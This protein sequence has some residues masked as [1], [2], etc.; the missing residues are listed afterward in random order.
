MNIF[1]CFLNSERAI[2]FRLICR[3][4]ALM[5][6]WLLSI[7]TGFCACS[8]DD[9]TSGEVKVQTI[10]D[11]LAAVRDYVPLYAVIAHR[12]STYWAPEETESAWRWAREM[13]ADYLESD[14]QCSKDGIIIANHD[15]SLKRT[16]NIEEV[17][18]AGIPETRI[19]FYESLG[20]SHDDATEQYQRDQ[21]S[22]QPYYM[23][24]YYYA[25]LL[26]LDAGKW[27]N[28]ALPTQAR[29]PFVAS[30]NGSFI[31]GHLRYSTGQY[32]STLQ[33]QIAYASGKMLR[34]G[35]DGERVLPYHI[36]PEYQGMTLR[37]IWQVITSKK[38]YDD[39]YM[40]FLDY[41]FTDAYTADPQDTG[42]RPGIYIEFKEPALNPDNMEQRVY[43]ILDH[44]GWN[45]ITQPAK[46]TAFYVG[47]KVNVGRTS[48]KVIL[49]TF[50]KEA[51]S[52]AN[53]IFQERVP[54]CYLLWL[55]IPP[56]PD[57]FDLTTPKGFAQAIKWAQDNGAH[58]M[59]PSIAGLPNNYS[60]LNAPWQAR[61]TR[62]SGMLNHPYSFD[63]QQQMANYV[64]TTAEDIPADG[65]F[66]NRS[67]LTLQYLIDKGFRGRSG[68]P[69]P[70][71][72]DRTYDNS[73]AP[74]TVPDAV[75]TLER[76][77]Y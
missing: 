8:D 18:G 55:N 72:P 27:F 56:Q 70:F 25:E 21:A 44:E 34:R 54:M 71:H 23:Q 62:R 41:D 57:D 37:Q 46:E 7:V 30:R 49:Q 64:G 20:F 48:G 24:S 9:D 52:R 4:K 36:K 12:G 45:I 35:D 17:F 68:L 50:S 65:C 2:P 69:N 73:Q 58:I 76:L 29:K 61:L 13:G 66:T 42:H 67:D 75:Q 19:Q 63:T 16:T 28:K 33:D 43:D 40:D 47:G 74:R 38:E 51:L 14:L 32:V 3:S 5:V 22:F 26:M 11:R 60:E 10:S 15:E 53:A 39:I 59:G 6:V 77:G 31:G 1:N